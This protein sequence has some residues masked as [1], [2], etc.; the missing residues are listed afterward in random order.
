MPC[1]YVTHNV[2]EALAIAEHLVLLRDGR[3]ESEGAPGGAPLRPRRREGGGGRPREHLRRAGRR[4][5]RHA[6]GSRRSSWRTARRVSVPLAAERTVGSR[7]TLAIRAEDMLVSV[8]PIRGLSARN[9]YAGP[10]HDAGAN[11]CRRHAPLLGRRRKGRAMARAP[12]ARGRRGPSDRAGVRRVARRQEPL[13][14][15]HLSPDSIAASARR[16]WRSRPIVATASARPAA[17]VGHR[18]VERVE[19]PRRSRPRPTSRRGRR[20]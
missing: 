15:P 1:L 11:R 18:A 6:G 9:V 14:P 2:G 12:D 19:S 8:E 20:S 7:L 16:L 13:D 5:R 17:L 3:V 10:R 4:A